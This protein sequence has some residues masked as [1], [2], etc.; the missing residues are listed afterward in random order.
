MGDVDS[1]DY[2]SGLTEKSADVQYA[3][4]RHV[5]CESTRLVYKG[6]RFVSKEARKDAALIHKAC[7]DYC[8]LKRNRVNERYRWQERAPTPC[9][10]LPARQYLSVWHMGG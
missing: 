8:T 1:R 9:D 3:T 4:F 7:S 6:F 10:V 5:I 2:A